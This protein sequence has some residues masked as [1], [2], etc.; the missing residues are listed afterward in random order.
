M[1]LKKRFLPVTIFIF[2]TGGVFGQ[3]AILSGPEKGSYSRFVNDIIS[4]VGA[5]NGIIIQN[6]ST[7]GSAHNFKV[8]TNPS[9]DDRIALIQS[10]YLNL[11]KA[12]DKLNNTNK[13]GSLRVLM[14]LASEEIHLV[15]KKSSGLKKLQDL[16][17]KKVGIGNEDQGSSATGTMLEKRSKVNW[18]IYNVGFDQLLKKLSDGSIDA[19]LIVGSAP[20]SL[21]EID[22]QVMMDGIVLLELD[23]LG[24]LS[25]Y[26]ENDTVHAGE[27]KWL[28]KDV[29]T[30]SVR[31]LLVVNDAKLSD[32]DKQTVVAI[33]SGIVKNLDRLR[34]TGHPKWKT[35]IVPDDQETIAETSLASIKNF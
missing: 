2:L 7:G 25:Q 28:D 27:Y 17:K 19:G 32:A 20:V 21:L 9:S 18:Y 6:K 1:N 3:M 16:D 22:P 24:G 26:Y 11:M 5:N 13:T 8:L 15:A 29:P 10:D 4:L 31:T 34:S 33:K 30:F 35:V 23:D 12:Q 14:E